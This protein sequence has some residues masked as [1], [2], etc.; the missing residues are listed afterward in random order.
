MLCKGGRRGGGYVP[1]SQVCQG[2]PTATRSE[3][4]ARKD[5]SL[6]PSEGSMVLPSFLILASRTVRE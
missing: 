3:K 6:E 5:S 2:V 1:T 4:E